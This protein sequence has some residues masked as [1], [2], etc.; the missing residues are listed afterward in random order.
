[1]EARETD[2]CVIGAGFAG[3][4]AARRIQEAGHSVVLLEARDRIGGRVWG[5]P[6]FDDVKI[7]V[8]GTWIG[9]GHDKL[10]AL[11]REAGL[12][13]YP[14]YDAGDSV[15]MLNGKAQR[16]TGTLPKIN[17]FALAI[18]GL[19]IKRIDWMAKSLPIDEPWRASKARDWDSQSVGGWIDSLFKLN[20]PSK[21]ARL[22][23][24]QMMTGFF[25][26]DPDEISLMSVLV[27][28]RGAGSMEYSAAVK[29]GA[30]EALIDGGMHLVAEYLASKLGDCIQLSSPVRT[31]KQDGDGV[32]VV[33]DS[34]SVR[35]KRVIVTAPPILAGQIQ[36][37][38]ALPHDHQYLLQRYPP[39][40]IMRAV[41]GYD[42][43]F[44][45]KEGLTGETLAPGHACAFSIDQSPKS[46][47]IGILSVYSS[48]PPALRMAKLEPAERRGVFL[49][50]L[51]ARLG[52]KAANPVHYIEA[53]W[54]DE[55]WSQGGMIGH[56]PPGILTTY[57][58]TLRVPVG[59]I[60]W[61]GTETGTVFHGLIEGAI[62]S[63]ERAAGEVLAAL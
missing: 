33:S 36:Y 21:T 40:T 12:Q 61:A 42:E 60:H 5:H 57:G 4:T 28:A 43:P 45:R 54:S 52:P 18:L 26:A 2:I 11:V 23:M 35:A 55:R 13:T 31:I 62:H 8:G 39:G 34:G 17:L 1:M 59:R 7:D 46:G 30:D 47:E 20:V 48:G 56:L 41:V 16:Y 27:L 51:T 25:A 6:Y 15:L 3:M 38:P 49:D 44:W 14:T 58:Q 19:T 9:H 10:R 63:G 32:E 53:N 24:H 29:G 37:D 50:A 22:F